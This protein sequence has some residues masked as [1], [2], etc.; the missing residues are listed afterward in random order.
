MQSHK[1]RD[2]NKHIYV[3]EKALMELMELCEPLDEKEIDDLILKTKNT[4]F[5]HL[6]VHLLEKKEDIV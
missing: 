4:K 5:N 1:L 6:R 3:S 2:E